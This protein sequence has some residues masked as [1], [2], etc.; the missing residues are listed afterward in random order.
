MLTSKALHAFYV[1]NAF[2]A[3][4]AFYGRNLLH[5]LY[6]LG[7][8]ATRFTC[9]TYLRCIKCFT[10]A[11]Y[12]R[13][14]T[15]FTR[16]MQCV[17]LLLYNLHLVIFIRSSLL[18]YYFASAVQLMPAQF[19]LASVSQSASFS[20]SLLESIYTARSIPTW[21]LSF[22]AS[23]SNKQN[24]SVEQNIKIIEEMKIKLAWWSC[25]AIGWA[26]ITSELSV[27]LYSLS[28]WLC[29]QSI[30]HHI[31]LKRVR[32]FLTNSIQKPN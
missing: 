29:S 2:C 22:E 13:C 3:R 27:L 32:T 8:Y 28:W 4:N 11:T 19:A 21:I 15:C 9:A 1:C 17:Q 18:A 30:F 31:S 7:T 6:T 16:A 14:V 10:R 5:T 12:L 24:Y 20:Y 23:F 26:C 25:R